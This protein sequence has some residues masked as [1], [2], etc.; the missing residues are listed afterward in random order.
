MLLIALFY[1][2]IARMLPVVQVF[3]KKLMYVYY[4][5][6]SALYFLMVV[7]PIVTPAINK[8]TTPLLIGR[9]VL[10]EEWLPSVGLKA[11][12]ALL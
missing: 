3:C 4:S 12:L 2:W 1:L 5:G 10:G 7:T 9:F 8:N 11:L 6:L